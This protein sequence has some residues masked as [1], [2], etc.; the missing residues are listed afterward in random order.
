MCVNYKIGDALPDKIEVESL[1]PTSGAMSI[2]EVLV[3]YPVKPLVCTG[4]HSL[5]HP[6]SACPSTTRRWVVKR[7]QQEDHTVQQETMEKTPNCVSV[8][9]DSIVINEAHRPAEVPVGS[10]PT[11]LSAA[12]SPTFE[13]S[14]S[15]VLVFKNLKKVDE[16]D[17]KRA[18]QDNVEDDDA[19]SLIKL[20]R[21]V[22]D[23]PILVAPSLCKDKEIVEDLGGY[24]SPDNGVGVYAKRVS[25]PTVPSSS[26]GIPLEEVV[27]EDYS[28]E[29]DGVQHMTDR[30]AIERDTVHRVAKAAFEANKND[31]E[32]LFRL[33]LKMMEVQ[34]FLAKKGL[35]MAE[36]ERETLLGDEKFNTGLTSSQRFVCGRDEFG[37][38]KFTSARDAIER[39][40]VHRV[41]KAAF[42]TN[43]HD[44]DELIRLRLKFMEVQRYLAKRGLSMAECEKESL[45]GDAELN[46]GLNNPQRV[47]C[48][49]DEFGLPKFAKVNTGTPTGYCKKA[50][51]EEEEVL[52]MDDN[53][54]GGPSSGKSDTNLGSVSPPSKGKDTVDVPV[55]PASSPSC[56][57]SWSNVV[58]DSASV[59]ASFEYVPLEDGNTVISPPEEEL[60]LGNDKFKNC[61]VGTFSKKAPP[62]KVVSDFASGVWSKKGVCKVAQKNAMTFLFHFEDSSVMNGYLAKGTWYVGGKP[63]L[64]KAWGASIK[65]EPVSSIPLWV[66]ISNIPDSYWTSKGL[67]RLASVVG[68]PL[69]AD[70]LTSK[71]EVLPFAK[72]CVTYTL[73]TDLPNSVKVI[74]LD[75]VSKE[76]LTSEVS[77]SYPNKPLMCTGCCSLGHTIGACPKATRSWVRKEKQPNSAFGEEKVG[78]NKEPIKEGSDVR[79]PV[80]TEEEEVITGS[81]SPKTS[82]ED[83]KIA[84]AGEEGIK[85][86]ED[87]V[88]QTVK[89]KKSKKDHGT[90]ISDNLMGSLPI[91]NAVSRAI[92]KNQKKTVHKPRGRGN[93]S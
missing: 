63:M 64:V 71:L 6:I 18:F 32:E 86:A 30:D 58:K 14:P 67:S 27:V 91:Y 51:S 93:S 42:E 39:D 4:C 61:I 92:S 9:K 28:S 8:Q 1:D 24:S 62:F 55:L 53:I 3:H 85:D 65:D 90:S 83:I 82:E 66:K 43:K 48:G 70:Q 73:G 80:S 77:F 36:C 31:R 45:M 11:K 49:R 79:H 10:S 81:L 23:F 87:G 74:S 12:T 25:F 13:D 78:V 5:G 7:K 19:M 76:K 38:P 89:A 46:V 75:P 60:L 88:W 57:K 35:S 16:I 21:E 68:P 15:P 56:F 41:A 26:G 72:F 33:K 2:V 17:A 37:L 40:T 54:I 20:R 50:V 22:E 59:A 34:K 84:E 29:E 47:V 52:G 44:R 69:C